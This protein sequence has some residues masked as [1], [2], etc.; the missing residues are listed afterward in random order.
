[1][2]NLPSSP[3]ITIFLGSWG[4]INLGA[5]KKPT[6]NFYDD[7]NAE[8]AVQPVPCDLTKFRKVLIEKQVGKV[9]N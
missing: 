2:V 9:Y 1:M 4:P 6:P 8:T 3:F 7:K 5:K